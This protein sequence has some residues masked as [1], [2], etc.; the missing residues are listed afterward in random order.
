VLHW[1]CCAAAV[2]HILALLCLCF[3]FHIRKIYVILNSRPLFCVDML[4]PVYADSL[5]SKPAFYCLSEV[6][7]TLHSNSALYHKH[8]CVMLNR[9]H[10]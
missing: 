3:Y 7:D 4:D 10:R 2:N 1:A 5:P 9:L 8:T 6:L